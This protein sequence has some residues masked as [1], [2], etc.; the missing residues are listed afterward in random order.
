MTGG[1]RGSQAVNSRVEG[2]LRTL[3]G[4]YRIIH[5]TGTLDIRKFS[6][7]K[8]RLP[9]ALK[10]NYLLFIRINPY[11][12]PKIYEKSDIVV[13]RAG[14]NTVSEIMTVKRPAILIPL[15]ISFLDEQTKNANIARDW[16]IARVIPQEKLTSQ[17]LL[18]EIDG[19]AASFYQIISRVK[20]KK[21]L[22]VGASG[23]VLSILNEY[24]R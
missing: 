1:S 23:K 22:D 16:G 3:L 14:A 10:E 20:V 19:L 24:V 8:Q 18:K 15:A 5:Q 13:S 4:R 11:T 12:M 6:D 17:L 9:K 7:I 2:I 21:S